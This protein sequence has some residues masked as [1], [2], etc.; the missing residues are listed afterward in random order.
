LDALKKIIGANNNLSSND[1]LR[2]ATT[3]KDKGGL[4]MIFPYHYHDLM[5]EQVKEVLEKRKNTNIFKSLRKL[6]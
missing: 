5:R 6:Y 4:G 3:T 1:L 2:F